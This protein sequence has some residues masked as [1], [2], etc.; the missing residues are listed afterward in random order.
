MHIVLSWK[1]L[2]LGCGEK[3][4]FRD[5]AKEHWVSRNKSR[6]KGPQWAEMTP[7]R[8]NGIVQKPHFT[9]VSRASCGFDDPMG[10]EES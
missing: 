6:K 2:D 3:W 9:P 7:I 10:P 1:S 5:T 4:A 8:R